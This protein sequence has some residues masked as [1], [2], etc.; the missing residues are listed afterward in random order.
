MG[1]GTPCDKDSLWL[2]TRARKTVLARFLRENLLRE[3]L[4]LV[5]RKGSPSGTGRPPQQ[6][7][8]I[9]WVP[10]GFSLERHV[11]GQG[12]GNRFFSAAAARPCLG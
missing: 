9:P 3:S 5:P 1:G 2:G 7:M 12:P 10:L 6:G 11:Q 8:R 4:R